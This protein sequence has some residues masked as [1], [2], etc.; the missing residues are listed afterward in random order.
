MLC[1]LWD[2]DTL[3]TER[4]DLCSLLRLGGLV[5]SAEVTPYEAMFKK[6]VTQL[7]PGSL[8]MLALETQPPQ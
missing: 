1:L 6:K 8:V 5:T 2:F 7:L 3:P 4:W